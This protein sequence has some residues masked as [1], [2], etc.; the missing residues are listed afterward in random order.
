MLNAQQG[1]SK[2]ITLLVNRWNFKLH[3]Q[4]YRHTNDLNSTG[5][6]AQEAWIAI[7]GSLNKLHDT[8]KFGV[9]ALSIASRK[10]IDWIRKRQVERKRD[11]IREMAAA[12]IATEGES[13]NPMMQSLGRAL[14]AL[15]DDQRMILSLYYMESLT[16]PDIA[17]VIGVPV[18]TVKSRLFYAREN[19]KKI[20][21]KYERPETAK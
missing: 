17:E 7:L 13:N 18:G 5:D 8:Q 3:K 4:I 1:D 16:V 15:P 6:I 11:E 21:K 14:K 10:A 2:A 9:W 19:L 20:I 12:E